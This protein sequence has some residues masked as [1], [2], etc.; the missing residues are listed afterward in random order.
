MYV[1]YRYVYVYSSVSLSF[2]SNVEISAFIKASFTRIVQLGAL[3]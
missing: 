2:N 3:V 1:K